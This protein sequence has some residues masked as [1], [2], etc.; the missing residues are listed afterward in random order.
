[1]VYMGCAGGIDSSLEFA[2]EREDAPQGSVTKKL[3]LKGL[4]GGHSGCDIH[5]GRGNANKLLAR[6]LA[7]HAE[8]LELR[9]IDF[10]GGSLRNAIPREGSVTL[11]LPQANVA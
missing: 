6:F 11:A 8:E 7:S 10:T 4:K 3:I 9:L 5:T 2:I 1:E